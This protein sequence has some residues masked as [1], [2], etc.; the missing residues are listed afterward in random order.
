M[1]SLKTRTLTPIEHLRKLLTSFE[2]TAHSWPPSGETQTPTRSAHCPSF[3]LSFHV[4]ILKPDCCSEV[5][6][7]ERFSGDN[8]V[9]KP[10]GEGIPDMVYLGSLT[11]FDLT[12]AWTQDK[13]VPLVREITFENGEVCYLLLLVKP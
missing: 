13:C 10:V 5:S 7:S 4:C 12:Y 9:Y 11:N 2:M 3:Q 6:K 8:V 1:V